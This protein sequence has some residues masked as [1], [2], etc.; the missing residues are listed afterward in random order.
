M[1]ATWSPW[2]P[3]PIRQPAHVDDAAPDVAESEYDAAREAAEAEG[4]QR[5]L[6]A[7]R[8]EGY[9]RG[10]T[11]GQAAGRERW[12]QQCAAQARDME[13][14]L[15]GVGKALAELDAVATDGMLDTTLA[16]A[17]YL[18]MSALDTSPAKVRAVILQVL[19]TDP[20]WG[21]KAFLV[22]NPED[23]AVLGDT[24][25]DQIVAAGLSI[26]PDPAI[27][28]GDC[29]ITGMRGAVKVNREARWKSM[30]AHLRNSGNAH[31]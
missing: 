3:P 7:G 27:A 31:D 28:R 25:A 18:A 19:S 13:A 24:V 11:D 12:D 4:R 26:R 22:V 2:L 10:F 16:A 15:R 23:A 20:V 29:V 21:D 1:T 5:G 14:L 8:A 30:L 9:R 17:R 6:E